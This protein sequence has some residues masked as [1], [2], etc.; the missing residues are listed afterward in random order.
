MVVAF[1]ASGHATIIDAED[2]RLK[3]LFRMPPQG[4]R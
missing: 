3:A 4:G 2:R 1:V